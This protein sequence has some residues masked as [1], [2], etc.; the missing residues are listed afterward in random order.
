[1]TQFIID[2]AQVE[3]HNANQRGALQADYDALGD[4]L[5]RRGVDIEAL[6]AK[7]QTFAVA[8]PTGAWARAARA[9]HASPAWASHA[10]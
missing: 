3:Q 7:A 4:M 1:M 6:T 9:S 2:P 5:S 8:V 10:T